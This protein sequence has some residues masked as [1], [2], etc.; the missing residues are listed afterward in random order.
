MTTHSE[1]I[2]KCG[3]GAKYTL[4]S[5][6]SLGRVAITTDIGLPGVHLESR[7]CACRSHCSIHIDATEGAYLNDK[8]VEQIEVEQIQRL[9]RFTGPVVAA[10]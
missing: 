7:Q 9:A 5:F 8:A 6:R 1:I 10:P 4:E 3:C 2:T